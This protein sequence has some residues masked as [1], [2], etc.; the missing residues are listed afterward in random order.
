MIQISDC[1]F[2][3]MYITAG[4]VSKISNNVFGKYIYVRTKSKLTA[5]SC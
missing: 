4:V 5:F 2:P 1:Y 3:Y